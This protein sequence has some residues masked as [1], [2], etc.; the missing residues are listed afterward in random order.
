[1]GRPRN[2]ETDAVVESAMECFWTNGYANT[3]PAQLAEATGIGKGSLYN[4][5]GSKR[6]L[7]DQ[8]MTRYA[9]RGAAVAEEALNRP[10]GTRE[11]IRGFLRELVDIDVAQ[12]V[13]RGC[14]A[15]NTAVEM[16]GHDP[17]VAPAL[18]AATEPIITALTARIDQGR[19]DGD[20][21][22]DIDA[23]AQ[24]EFLLN[25]IA[26]LR[27]MAR[28]TADVAVLHRIIDTALTTL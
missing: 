3:S 2:F 28:T 5:F 24:A 14:L 11:C 20:V 1:M 4:T 12:P 19:R 17:S 8:A 27:V 6:E 9:R 26:G 22:A 18:H 13:R 10:G 25:T 23:R 16:A 15:V 7:F 21:R